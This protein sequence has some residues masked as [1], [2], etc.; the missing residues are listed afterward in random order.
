MIYKFKYNQRL[1]LDKFNQD[2]IPQ[3]PRGAPQIDVTFD[4]DA[5]GILNVSAVDKRTGI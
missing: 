4:Y 5:I 3:A 2:G 1:I